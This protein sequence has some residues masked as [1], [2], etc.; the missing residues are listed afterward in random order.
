[1]FT[2]GELSQPS[3]V[4]PDPSQWILQGTMGSLLTGHHHRGRLPTPGIGAA[5]Y[6]EE[7]A[8]DSCPNWPRLPSGNWPGPSIVYGLDLAVFVQAIRH[9]GRTVTA[10]AG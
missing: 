1:M 10:V 7:Y 5:I 6:L 3:H 4:V 9:N 8:K 2:G